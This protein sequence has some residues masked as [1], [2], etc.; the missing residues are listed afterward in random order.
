M[1]QAISVSLAAI[2]AVKQWKYKPYLLD[3]KPGEGEAQ[4]TIASGL[5][6]RRPFDEL[7]CLL[8]SLRIELPQMV[9]Q[10]F[11]HDAAPGVRG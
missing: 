3:N 9:I 8:G 7:G 2:E 5:R 4:L 10:V 6:E 1:F 11:V